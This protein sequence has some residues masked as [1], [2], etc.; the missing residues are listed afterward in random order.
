MIFKLQIFFS[1]QDLF[2]IVFHFNKTRH[3]QVTINR[4]D[5]YIIN[6]IVSFYMH[7]PG[8]KKIKD[9]TTQRKKSQAPAREEK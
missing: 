6:F 7:D 2:I 4:V 9:L 3:L 1:K 5:P 8:W